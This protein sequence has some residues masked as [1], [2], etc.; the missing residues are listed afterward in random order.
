MLG[1]ALIS[2]VEGTRLKFEQCLHLLVQIL[3]T[4]ATRVSIKTHVDKV[5][6]AVE[7]FEHVNTCDVI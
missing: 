3:L 5:L 7:A 4:L 6:K 2:Q 1:I